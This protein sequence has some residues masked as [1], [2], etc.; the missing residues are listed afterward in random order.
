VGSRP[1]GAHAR[2]RQLARSGRGGRW[3]RRGPKDTPPGFH[4]G[5]DGITRAPRGQARGCGRYFS[6]RR[7]GA[8]PRPSQTP[9]PR[10][11][12]GE[13]RRV[14][15][16]HGGPCVAR[17][18]RALESSA[19]SRWSWARALAQGPSLT[20]RGVS[21][22]GG[23]CGLPDSRRVR[24]FVMDQGRTAKARRP[25][26]F[27]RGALRGCPPQRGRA[28]ADDPRPARFSYRNEK[29]PGLGPGARK[30]PFTAAGPRTRN[31]FG[32]P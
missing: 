12:C 18:R 13:R 30:E 7:P 19:R 29:K 31:G 8:E 3:S 6:R 24:L 20:T 21:D 14:S 4:R 16:R 5:P 11:M 23:W 26:L 1:V 9:T 22:P 10:L 17:S 32:G 27:P 15:G 28:T 25:F 2:S